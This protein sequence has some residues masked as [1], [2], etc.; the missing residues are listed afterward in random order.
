MATDTAVI[1]GGAIGLAIAWRLAEA[2]QRVAVLDPSPGRG[3]SWVA[4][5]MLAPATE[6]HYGEEALV[7]LN[8][9]SADRWPSFAA[10]LD[11]TAGTSSGYRSCGTLVVA[12]DAD[13]VA[14]LD[15]LH[16]FQRSLGLAVDRLTS[17]EARRL[18]PALAT[19]VRGGLLA[20]DDH[21]VDN[22]LL[23][24]A[25]LTACRRSGVTF[26]EE[27]AVALRHGGGSITGVDL[28]NDERIDAGT[29]VL[30]AG[31]WSDAIEG[32]PQL[33]VRPV[34]GQLIHLRGPA[35]HPIVDHNV[36]TVGAMPGRPSVYVVARGDGRVVVGA[37]AEEMG[38]DTSVTAGAVLDLLRETFDL[39]PGITE[40]E[41]TETIAGL[42]PGTP[43]NAPIIGRAPVD[44][45]V[46]AT[47]H[48]RNGILLAPLTADAVCDLVTTG[49][50]DPRVKAFGPDRF[51]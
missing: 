4:A 17:R 26:V 2:G 24:G 32:V 44:G 20:R 30:A 7:E 50:L 16:A 43:D 34:K 10:E 29:V 3:A 27:H 18:E 14:A 46:V 15:E 23:V 37:T 22:R 28:A 25:L 12:R 39:L 47:G 1:G 51:A 6:A 45:L 19:T 9:A 41:L 35:A 49:E 38:F 5:G 36:R 48:F 11:A 8:V 33:P 40:L 21:Q 31:A 13:D 42:R